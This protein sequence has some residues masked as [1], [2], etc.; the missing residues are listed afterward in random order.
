MQISTLGNSGNYNIARFANSSNT[1]CLVV[2]DNVRVGIGLDSPSYNLHVNS[3][4]NTSSDGWGS[5]F[6]TTP[7]SVFL[8]HKDGDGILVESTSNS[9]SNYLLYLKSKSLNI[10]DNTLHDRVVVTNRGFLSIGG[11]NPRFPLSVGTLQN[12]I[13]TSDFDNIGTTRYVHMSVDQSTGTTSLE[14]DFVGLNYTNN[15]LILS[16]YFWGGVWTQV[17]FYQSS[18]RRIKTNIVD[19]SDNVALDM[20]RAI[21]C[22]YYEYKDKITRGSEKTIGF[23]AQEVRDVMPM[24]VGMQKS[25]IPNEM[26]ILDVSW[27]EVGDE[28]RLI[29]ELDD[30]SG[31]KYRFYLSDDISGNSEI[32]KEIVG[33]EDNTFTLEKKYKIVFCYG[34]EVDDFHTLD[35]NKLF[36]LNFSATQELDRKVITL[37][38]EKEEL[39]EEIEGLKSE[40]SAIK[41]HLGL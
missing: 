24:A 34:K 11:S 3:T 28:Y 30:V 10:G 6:Y 9:S 4:N 29:T 17:A 26:R 1:S 19:V 38:R 32:K 25:I 8:S 13:G 7:T 2:K 40:L 39:Q 16:A 31:V 15:N 23:I 33:N 21:P 41:A 22:R 14:T 12:T 37:E 27:I 20:L 36:A 5:R 35:K 18:D